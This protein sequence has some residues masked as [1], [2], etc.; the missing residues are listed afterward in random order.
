MKWVQTPISCIKL[1][2]ARPRNMHYDS[3]MHEVKCIF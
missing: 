3:S 1:Q 2:I